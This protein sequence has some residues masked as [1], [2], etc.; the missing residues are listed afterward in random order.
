MHRFSELSPPN[1]AAEEDQA[2]ADRD[3]LSSR[4][5]VVSQVD[6]ELLQLEFRLGEG[7]NEGFPEVRRAEIARPRWPMLPTF[8]L[9]RSRQ[10]LRRTCMHYIAL[11]AGRT[12]THAH[13]SANASRHSSKR[14]LLGRTCSIQYTCCSPFH[15]RYAKHRCVRLFFTLAELPMPGFQIPRYPNTARRIRKQRKRPKPRE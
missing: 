7:E 2:V 13:A 6:P 11:P 5:R 10:N 15:F 3:G 9:W 4:P 1:A 8:L 14:H 12:F